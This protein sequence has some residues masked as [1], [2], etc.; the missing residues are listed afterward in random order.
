MDNN[1]LY[2]RVR[3]LSADCSAVTFDFSKPEFQECFIEE[4]G[5]EEKLKSDFPQLYSRFQ[6]AIIRD[7][8]NDR[9]NGQV[10]D[11]G[12]G[13][14]VD[15]FYG[16]YSMDVKHI[17][18]RAVTSLLEDA[19]CI[20]HRLRVFQENGNMI[21]D[22][23]QADLDTHHAVLNV[24]H[25][26]YLEDRRLHQNL[27]FQYFSTWVNTKTGLHAAYYTAEDECRW[28]PNG[29]IDSVEMVDP[30]HKNTSPDSYI[31]VC[32]DRTPATGE[33][34][35][36]DY[37]AAIE[38]GRQKLFLD[39]GGKV[40]LKQDAGAFTS[41]VKRNCELKLD[42][43]SG[44]ARYNGS[45]DGKFSSISNGFTF[46]LDR[47][48]GDIVPSERLPIK[49]PVDFSLKLAFNTEKAGKQTVYIA[50]NS[51]M[52]GVYHI[53]QLLFLWGCIAPDTPI[54]MSDKSICSAKDIKIGDQVALEEGIGTVKE[55]YR[56]KELKPAICLETINGKKL[57]CT[58]EHPIM[59]K[60][61]FVMAGEL[62]GADQV[63]DVTEGFVKIKMLYKVNQNEVLNFDIEPDEGKRA[64][65][66]CDGI[67]TGDNR[68]QKDCMDKAGEQKNKKRF[69]TPDKEYLRLKA[70][71]EGNR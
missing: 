35:D 31:V 43:Q 55:I 37:E 6:E 54:L 23:G 61:G 7:Q 10:D 71:F 29:Y 4:L 26:A 69:G 50:S 58:E 19:E 40:T 53:S 32:Y 70:F 34:I 52:S 24:D 56:G 13:D 46:S 51:T 48:W 17:K 14:L 1:I 16:F 42:C 30:R 28:T 47:D 8:K 62:N 67:V 57:C 45:W 60:R 33:T 18:C 39:V 38:G 9:K 66:I 36:Y 65:I 12:Y 59:T 20:S 44:G 11:T 15:I 27:I 68:T 2:N 22:I 64:V 25:E 49:D 5:G 63:K 41:I 3:S 21:F